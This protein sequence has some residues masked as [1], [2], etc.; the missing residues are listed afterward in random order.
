MEVRW[1]FEFIGESMK[2]NKISPKFLF[3]FFTK[4]EIKMTQHVKSRFS[5]FFFFFFSLNH[6]CSS[7]FRITDGSKSLKIAFNK[8]CIFN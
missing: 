5:L 6:I 2:I 1:D 8:I 3:F 7:L 4:I